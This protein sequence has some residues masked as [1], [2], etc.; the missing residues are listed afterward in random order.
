MKVKSK[1]C[2]KIKN[3]VSDPTMLKIIA[4]KLQDYSINLKS[5]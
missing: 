2:R 5:L 1:Y 3:M 4:L